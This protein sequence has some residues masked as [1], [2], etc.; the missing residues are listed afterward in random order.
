MAF[1]YWISSL[2]AY[3]FDWWSFLNSSFFVLI[4]SRM[5]SLYIF[6][7]F[8]WHKQK[9]YFSQLFQVLILDHGEL[10][11]LLLLYVDFV[12]VFL[13]IELKHFY[14]V[15]DC[16]DVFLR[17]Q[18]VLHSAKGWLLVGFQYKS[19]VIKKLG[20]LLLIHFLVIYNFRLIHNY[21]LYLFTLFIC[22]FIYLDE[23]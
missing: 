15:L 5:R 18:E 22:S 13:F 23:Y 9:S 2:T 1:S 20:F 14:S 7:T 19:I 4:S 11:D 17:L 12:Q 10:F 8:I 3:S 21:L 6:V 16:F